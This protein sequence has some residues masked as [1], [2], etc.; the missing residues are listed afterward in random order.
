MLLA[1][2]ESKSEKEIESTFGISCFLASQT[3][4]PTGDISTQAFQ[5]FVWNIF[6]SS[7]SEQSKHGVCEQA[8]SLKMYLSINLAG[9]RGVWGVVIFSQVLVDY[10]VKKRVATQI[11]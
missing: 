10:R 7:Y 5:V 9:A 3:T 6:F 1:T 2:V 11:N 4:E 8:C